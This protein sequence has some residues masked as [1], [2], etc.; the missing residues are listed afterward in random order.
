MPSH[1]TWARFFTPAD[2]VG[3]HAWARRDGSFEAHDHD[4]HE[5]VLITGGRAVHRFAHQEQALARGSFAVI[6]PGA[7]HA[8]EQGRGLYGIDCAFTLAGLKRW[9]P[10][11]LDDPLVSALLV[12]APAAAGRHGVLTGALA[13]AAF[14]RCRPAFAALAELN[15]RLEP[16]LRPERLGRFLVALGRLA[17]AIAPELTGRERRHDPHPAAAATAR[18]LESDLARAWTVAELAA[19]AHLDPSG[20]T[21]HFRRAYGMPPLAWLN[22][23]RAERVAYLLVAGDQAI[24]AAGAEVGWFDPNY[25]AR[26]FRAAF[27]L[28]PSAYRFR[29]R[30]RGR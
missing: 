30:D 22:Q 16:E 13:P 12:H 24:G 8:Y 19:A 15:D 18:R 25:A 26:R 28:S 3:C 7:W 6:A 11:L 5:L 4:F 20:L 2:V 9:M 27:G 29:F 10:G 21:R 17:H 1:L 14:A 23:R